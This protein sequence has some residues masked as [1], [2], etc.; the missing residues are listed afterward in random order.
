MKDATVEALLKVGISPNVPDAN[1][2][3]A[4][5]VDAIAHVAHAIRDAGKWLG[6]ADASTPMGAPEA[7]GKAILDASENIAA[8]IRELAEAIDS[9]AHRAEASP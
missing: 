2:E 9:A 7:H 5:L 8:A 4:N 3:P 6:N 1:L